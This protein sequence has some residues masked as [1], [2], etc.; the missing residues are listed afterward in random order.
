MSQVTNCSKSSGWRGL[1]RLH[2]ACSAPLSM[3]CEAANKLKCSLSCVLQPSHPLAK[4]DALWKL[5]LQEKAEHRME[6]LKELQ[7]EERAAIFR[8]E[9]S[10]GPGETSGQGPELLEPQQR[11]EEV[12]R[13]ARAVLGC[14][15]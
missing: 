14:V 11:L 1:C 8:G 13:V 2:Q 10:D 3:R 4:A 5:W 6:R 12:R 9:H 15:L 7:E